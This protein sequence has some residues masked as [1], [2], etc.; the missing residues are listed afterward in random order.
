MQPW[1]RALYCMRPAARANLN[2]QG[3]STTTWA[4]DGVKCPG[5]CTFA[6]T[7]RGLLPVAIDLARQ[8]LVFYKGRARPT[9]ITRVVGGSRVDHAAYFTGP[10][11]WRCIL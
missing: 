2:S 1:R 11:P 6:L 7:I 3:K 8:V 10:A 4:F 5:C 9:T